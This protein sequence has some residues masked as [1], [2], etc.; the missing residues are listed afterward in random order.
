MRTHADS[1][2]TC[3]H[4]STSY[5]G[6]IILLRYITEPLTALLNPT[7]SPQETH[8]RAFVLSSQNHTFIFGVAAL[9]ELSPHSLLQSSFNL[10]RP[11]KRHRHLSWQLTVEEAACIS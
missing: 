2:T 10:D 8:H 6:L 3:Q 1:E 4:A 11:D 9:P 5:T 7:L